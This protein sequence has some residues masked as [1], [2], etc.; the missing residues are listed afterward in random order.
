M[1]RLAPDEDRIFMQ[2]RLKELQ[3]RRRDRDKRRD[4]QNKEIKEIIKK[5]QEKDVMKK[6]IQRRRDKVQEQEQEQEQQMNEDGPSWINNKRDEKIWENKLQR[7]KEEEERE[8]F[9]LKQSLKIDYGQNNSSKRQSIVQ[10][11]NNIV[12][13]SQQGKGGGLRNDGWTDGGWNNRN[14]LENELQVL[15]NAIEYSINIGNGDDKEDDEQT[16]PLIVQKKKRKRNEEQEYQDDLQ[17][18]QQQ[19]I[20]SSINHNITRKRLRLDEDDNQQNKEMNVDQINNNKSKEEQEMEKILEAEIENEFKA[21]QEEEQLKELNVPRILN[22]RIQ[23][24]RIININDDNYNNNNKDGNKQE[25]DEEEEEDEEDFDDS[26]EDQDQF[27]L[28]DLDLFFKK[29]QNDTIAL[30][31]QGWKE[32]YYDRKAGMGGFTLLSRMDASKHYL[33]GLIWTLHYYYRGILD[34]G[35]Y[36]PKHYACFASDIALFLIL[37][38]KWEREMMA[39]EY[40]K[41]V[42]KSDTILTINKNDELNEQRIE[43]EQYSLFG[44]ASTQ[45]M[46]SIEQSYQEASDI[47]LEQIHELFP[48]LCEREWNLGEPF[49]PAEQLLAVLPPQSQ[50]SIPGYLRELINRRKKGYRNININMNMKDNEKDND[51]IDDQSSLSDSFIFIDSVSISLFFFSFFLIINQ[52]SINVTIITAINTGQMDSIRFNIGSQWEE[53]GLLGSYTDPIHQ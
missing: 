8:L 2:R 26:I 38:Q 40:K 41:K 12:M 5:H 16:S 23:S 20:H 53:D 3:Y 21:I 31:R 27:G 9:E 15:N 28:K 35:W 22:K 19:D 4:D 17:D 32:R 48:L 7:M 47:Q 1:S 13:K 37:R 34:W 43:N 51:N 45:S 11:G 18:D 30:W 39:E 14:K 49:T 44:I 25:D 52:S 42:Q 6:K 33:D 50:N 36:Y 10:Y 46:I 24:R 29:D